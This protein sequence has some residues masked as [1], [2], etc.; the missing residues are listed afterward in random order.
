MTVGFVAAA[1]VLLVHAADA[2]Y[3]AYAITAAT[4]IV[5]A[6]TRFNPLWIFLIAAIA[7]AAGFV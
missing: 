7:G 3:A 1:A 2:S 5:G 4:A 6:A